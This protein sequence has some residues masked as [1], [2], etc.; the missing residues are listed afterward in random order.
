MSEWSSLTIPGLNTHCEARG[1]TPTHCRLKIEI[2]TDLTLCKASHGTG[3][4]TKP[5]ILILGVGTI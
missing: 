2:R 1:H 5:T 4:V 3:Y